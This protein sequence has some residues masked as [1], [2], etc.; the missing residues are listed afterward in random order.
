MAE[1]KK[2]KKLINPHV[3]DEESQ[4]P[5]K[6]DLPDMSFDKEA[7]DRAEDQAGGAMKSFAGK[8]FDKKSE[9]ADK[10]EKDI[11]KPG[12][13]QIGAYAPEPKPEDEEKKKMF[14]SRKYWA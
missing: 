10:A 5:V 2:L 1:F 13:V 9:E 14:Q 3:S 12:K 4:K 7:F 11:G 6:L 8:A